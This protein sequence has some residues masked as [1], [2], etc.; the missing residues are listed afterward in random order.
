MF[1]DTDEWPVTCTNCGHIMFK[2]IG[3]LKSASTVVCNLCRNELKFRN[4]TFINVL[5]NAKSTI[6]GLARI[7]VLT[8]KK[9]N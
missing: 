7:S 1:N 5:K 9:K 4:D 2:K 8:D 6:D 3:W